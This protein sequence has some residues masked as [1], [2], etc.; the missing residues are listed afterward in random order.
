MPVG[1]GSSIFA[2]STTMAMLHD[3]VCFGKQVSKERHWREE[4]DGETS[5]DSFKDCRVMDHFKINY[6]GV[7]F[8]DDLEGAY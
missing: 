7:A 3:Y 1:E 2:G 4:V 8:V 6:S 5:Q